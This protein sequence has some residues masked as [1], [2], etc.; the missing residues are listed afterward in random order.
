MTARIRAKGYKGGSHIAPSYS[1]FFFDEKFEE[2]PCFCFQYLHPKYT[3]AAC[4]DEQK[5]ALVSTLEK[6]SALTWIQIESMHRHGLGSEKISRDAIRPDIPAAVPKGATFL[7]I[8]FAGLAP[9]IGFRERNIMGSL[10]F[11]II[12]K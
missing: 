9:M 2:K 1:S 3:S 4:T 8:R 12:H 6:L 10:V 11:M 7:A 5:L